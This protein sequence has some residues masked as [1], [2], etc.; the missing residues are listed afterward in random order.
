MNLKNGKKNWK[1]YKEMIENLE[2]QNLKRE[3]DLN[4]FVLIL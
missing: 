2:K 3:D 4:D 1:S